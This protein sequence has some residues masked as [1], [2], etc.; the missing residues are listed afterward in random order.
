VCARRAWLTRVWVCVCVCVCVCVGV[1]QSAM[2][3]GFGVGVWQGVLAA[4]GVEVPHPVVTVHCHCWVRLPTR[5]NKGLFTHTQVRVVAPSAWKRAL[6][7]NG[8]DKVR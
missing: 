3:S 6:E 2:Q 8:K 7:L 1:P 4:L 5:R